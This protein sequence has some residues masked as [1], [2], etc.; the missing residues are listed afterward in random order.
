MIAIDTSVAGDTV[1]VIGAEVMP[2]IAA[3]TPLVPAVTE[4]ASPLE[5]A[6]LLSVATEDAADA[7]VTEAVK[8]WVVWSL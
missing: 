7:Q 4:V 3:V 6:A 5:P 8:S 2:P 1:R